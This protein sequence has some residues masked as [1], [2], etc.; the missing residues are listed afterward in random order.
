MLG[1]FCLLCCINAIA[2]W[3][4]L[5]RIAYAVHRPW[6][7]K[8]NAHISTV[9]AHRIFSIFSTY[10]NFRF[11]GDYTLVPQLPEQYLLISNHQ[12]I[13][14]IV[15]YMNYLGGKRVRF[16]AKKELADHVPLVS[17]MLKSDEHCLVRRTGSPSQ[18]MQAMDSFAQRVV[19]NNWIPILF[20]E[21]T[22]SK[23]GKVG[24][25]H[26]AGFRRFLSKAPMPVVVAAVDG[27]WNISSV[28]RL[29]TNLR[30]GAYRVKV[31]KIYPAPTTKEVQLKVLEESKELIQ[32]QLT[33]WRQQNR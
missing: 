3:A 14:D 19:R 27:G 6:C 15:V 32:E 1:I 28:T 33:V 17:V 18:A 9:I 25:F 4:L 5:N 30:G 24:T 13:L 31:L 20:P 8:I 2:G 21:G 12:S 26:S 11:K 16:V 10:L 22:R 7:K 23:D 29:A